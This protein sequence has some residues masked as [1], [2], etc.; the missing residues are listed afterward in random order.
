MRSFPIMSFK[1]KMVAAICVV[2]ILVILIVSTLSSLW[3]YNQI[4][5]QT[6]EQTQSL[7]KLRRTH[8]HSWL[9]SVLSRDFSLL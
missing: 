3:Y 4:V 9:Q 1:A 6:I 7:R 2:N 8:R 5:S